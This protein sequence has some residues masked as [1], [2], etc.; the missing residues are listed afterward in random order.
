MNMTYTIVKH[1]DARGL[2]CPLP[3]MRIKQTLTTINIGDVIR[4]HATD[5]G[6]IKDIEAFCKQT[7]N[8]L[9]ESCELNEVY[10]YIIQK[11]AVNN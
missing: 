8:D 5:P 7:G 6:S 9:L 3:I 1:I 2:N 11:G 4:V 10:E